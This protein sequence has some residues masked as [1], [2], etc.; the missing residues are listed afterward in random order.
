VARLKTDAAA[1]KPEAQIELAKHYLSGEGTAKNPVEAL[2]LLRL[3]AAQ[4]HTAGQTALGEL[5]LQGAPGIPGDAP[6]ARLWLG[7]AA[8]Q[9]DAKAAE[10]LKKL[11]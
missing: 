8:S 5:L 2:R 11:P 4:G 9:G 10:L 6:G 1:G 7:Q 3:T